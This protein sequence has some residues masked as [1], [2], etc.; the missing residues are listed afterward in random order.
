MVEKVKEYWFGLLLFLFSLLFLL[1]IAIVASAPHDDAKMR[2]FAPCTYIM[3]QELNIYASQR[4]VVGALGAVTQ[5]YIC[6]AKV[7][8][9][10]L[11]N[12]FV[13]KQST[14]WENYFFKADNFI[15]P[16]ELSEP[17]S[18]ELLKANRLN[19]DEPNDMFQDYQNNQSRE[20]NN[21]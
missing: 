13:G 11:K 14:P 4:D 21:D 6:Y 19:D 9:E 12:W 5:S 17:F 16:P 15:V 7:M 2:G 18:E 20:I 3:T 10:G 8:K 1:F